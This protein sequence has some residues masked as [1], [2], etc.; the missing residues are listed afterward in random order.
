MQA[1]RNHAGFHGTTQANGAIFVAKP[2]GY[3]KYDSEKHPFIAHPRM[4]FNTK[5]AYMRPGEYYFGTHGKDDDHIGKRI[6]D[7]A[8]A[9]VIL[10]EPD[11]VLEMVRSFC[12]KAAGDSDNIMVARLDQVY[13]PTVHRELTMFDSNAMVPSRVRKGLNLDTL[14]DTPV[15]LVDHISPALLAYR[16]VD[17]V[18]EMLDTLKQFQENDPRIV[19]TDIT[20][21]L[22]ETVEKP[23]KKGSESF[24][25]L[26]G[27]YNVGFAS[28]EVDANYQGK[29]TIK[30]APVTLTL[31]IDLLNRNSLKRLETTDPK[32]TLITW[33]ET[34][35][36]FRYATVVQS[37]DDI[38][39]WAGYYSNLRIVSK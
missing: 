15:P 2:D 25:Q 14:N 18:T 19:C 5:A 36:A 7:G 38:G 35:E 34:E 12:C 4:Y 23:T 16:A 27:E 26:K 3:W 24:K 17:C 22:Y 13:N 1:T 39:I 11:S 6:S 33:R 31:S 10:K 30:T 37:G 9:V 20:D 29:D 32:V 21:I 8:Y 28:L